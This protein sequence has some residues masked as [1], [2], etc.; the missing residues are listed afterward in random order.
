MVRAKEMMANGINGQGAMARNFAVNKYG[1][2]KVK[3]RNSVCKNEQEEQGKGIRYYSRES[4][5]S[6][7]ALSPF[8][9][10]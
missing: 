4:N 10:H 2:G 3:K 1:G 7:L 8:G 6:G 9:A 5:I